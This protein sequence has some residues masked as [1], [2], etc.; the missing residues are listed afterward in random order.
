LDW[1]EV[2]WKLIKIMV[3]VSITSFITGF[4][5]VGMKQ[6]CCTKIHQILSQGQYN[7][8]I[9]MKINYYF[10]KYWPMDDGRVRKGDK[11]RPLDVAGVIKDKISDKKIFFDQGANTG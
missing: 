8:L 3:H 11:L 1:L 7:W 10:D 9:C 4:I 5:R 6:E 2:I